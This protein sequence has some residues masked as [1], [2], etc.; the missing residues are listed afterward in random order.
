MSHVVTCDRCSGAGCVKCDYHGSLVIPERSKVDGYRVA[1]M[2]LLYGFV[3][4]LA[5]A[6]G[7]WV[8]RGPR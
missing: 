6:L 4:A 2:I 1:G 3:V 7:V 5:I 8:I